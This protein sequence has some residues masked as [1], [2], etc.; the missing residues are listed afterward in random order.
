MFFG[1]NYY[2]P[3]QLPHFSFRKEALKNNFV[4]ACTIQSEYGR[5]NNKTFMNSKLKQKIFLH[6]VW[7]KQMVDILKH[8][9]TFFKKVRKSQKWIMMSSILAKKWTKK[10]LSWTFSKKKLIRIVT[11][12]LFFERIEETKQIRLCGKVSKM[13]GNLMK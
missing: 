2:F 7:T 1:Q 4:W 5:R 13:D 6:T 11:F 8:I 12:L 9:S 10:P 3:P